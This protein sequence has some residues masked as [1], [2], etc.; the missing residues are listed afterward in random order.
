MGKMKPSIIA[1]LIFLTACAHRGSSQTSAQV[2]SAA[3]VMSL[4]S[5]QSITPAPQY[6]AGVSLKLY[7]CHQ[8][9]PACEFQL[10]SSVA[11]DQVPAVVSTNCPN[12]PP[13]NQVPL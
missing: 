11:Y 13:L 10:L 6:G 12:T 2:A 8:Y 9:T 4:C 1:L 5:E 7:V 3:Q